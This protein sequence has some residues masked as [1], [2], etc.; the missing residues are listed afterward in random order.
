MLSIC[1]SKPF[2]TI[3]MKTNIIQWN[4]NGFFSRLKE[5]QILTKEL[6]PAIVCI[7]ETNFNE[8]SNP[9]LKH[10]DIYKR[11]SQSQRRYH[12]ND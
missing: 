1:Q 3:Q 8:N 10:Y 11:K 2:H 12:N 4:I 7:Q 5:L 9:T 6:N